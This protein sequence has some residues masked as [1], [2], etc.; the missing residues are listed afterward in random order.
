MDFLVKLIV[1]IL[2]FVLPAIMKKSKA[3]YIEAS[4]QKEVKK[5]FQDNVRKHWG[6]TT[7]LFCM[8]MLTGCFDKTIYVPD[9]TPVKLR[10]TI[11]N[12]KVWIMTK[13]GPVAREMDLPEGWFAAP[14]NLDE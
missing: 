4:P 14:V 5:S 11:K 12:A 10:E 3:G 6:I 13:D 1:G 2:K 8:F 7:A 9:G